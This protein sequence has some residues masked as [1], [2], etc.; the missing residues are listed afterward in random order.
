MANACFKTGNFQMRLA[1]RNYVPHGYPLIAREYLGCEN[2]R[3]IM[4]RCARELV[5]DK[6]F[7]AI[8]WPTFFVQ[9]SSLMASFSEPRR[10]L[11]YDRAFNRSGTSTTEQSL[12]FVARSC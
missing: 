5:A 6:G 8:L 7:S 10:T 2:L 11:L 12:C 1:F 4:F 9:N 3:C